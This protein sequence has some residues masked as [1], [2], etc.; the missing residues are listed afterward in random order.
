MWPN[1]AAQPTASQRKR[2]FT[3]GGED[4]INVAAKTGARPFTTSKQKQ[5]YAHFLP[6]ARDRLVEPI[7]PEPMVRK[8]LPCALAIIRP[9]GIEPSKYVPIIKI[10]KL[11][12]VSALEVVIGKGIPAVQ[13]LG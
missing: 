13:P 9:K 11:I 8:S 2:S 12:L 3:A 1:T 7:L 10:V 5:R 6:R 4:K